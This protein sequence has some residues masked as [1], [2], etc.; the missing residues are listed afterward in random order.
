[1]LVRILF[2]FRPGLIKLIILIIT[3]LL[4]S[5]VTI[6]YEATSKVS[7]EENRGIPLSFLTIVGYAG[8]C[9]E[10]LYCRDASIQTFRPLEL[11]LDVLIWYGFS[12]LLFSGYKKIANHWSFGFPDKAQKR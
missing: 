6:G 12:C 4:A 7:W 2:F 5:F 3:M 8:P 9:S 10:S 1:M 11:L